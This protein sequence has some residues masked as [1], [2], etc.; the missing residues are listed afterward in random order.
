MSLKRSDSGSPWSLCRR[1]WTVMYFTANGRA[2]PC[3]IAPFSQ[4]GYENYTLG[5]ATQQTLPRNLDGAGLPRFPQ[6]ALV[7]TS[8]RPRVPVAACAGVCRM[9]PQAGTASPS[10]FRRSTKANRSPP[11]SPA[12]RA[13]VVDRVIVADGGSTDDT[14]ARRAAPAR[15]R[16]TPAAATAAPASPARKRPT[17]PTSSSSWTATAP[18]IRRRSPT[19]S[20]RH[21]LRPLRLRHR[22]AR[23]REARAGQHG[24]PPNSRRPGRRRA[25]RALYGV[26]YTDMCAYRAIPRDTLLA[27]GM[28]ELTYGWNLEMQMRVARPACAFSNCRS[29]IAAASAGSPRSPALCAVRCAPGRASSRPSPASPW[30]RGAQV[31]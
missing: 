21:S 5:D 8:R 2:L 19:W 29:P 30:S 26:R 31:R 15:S 10:S 22:F 1:P 18:T 24:K 9:P 16:S 7:G 25:D 4:R 12:C 6:G 20:P 3:C 23:A 11:S 27:L 13:T 17:T 28:R 14:S